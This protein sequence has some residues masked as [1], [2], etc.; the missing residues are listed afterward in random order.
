MR[1]PSTVA[2]GRTDWDHPLWTFF[3][4]RIQPLRLRKTKMW[5]Y[6]GSTCPSHPSPDK[7]STM[8]VET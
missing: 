1:E 7:L 3:S 5:A 8:E 2:M 6:L 4:R